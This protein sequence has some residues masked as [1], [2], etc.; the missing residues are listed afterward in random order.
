MPEC[1]KNIPG[2]IHVSISLTACEGN[3]IMQKQLIAGRRTGGLVLSAAALMLLAG[4]V[5]GPNY[6]EP[7]INSPESFTE[8]KAWSTAAGDIKQWWKNLNDPA[9]DSLVERAIKG[10]LDLREAEARVREARELRQ[11]ARSSELPTI[12]NSTGYKRQEDS[13]NTGSPNSNFP[14]PGNSYNAWNLG[15]DA[16]WELDFFGRVQRGVEAAEG[17]VQSAEFTAR[18][19]LVTLT[20]EVARNY[21]DLRTQQQRLT[22]TQSN[23]KTQEQTMS[24]AETRFKAGL[25]SE[26]DVAR[27][28]ANVETTRSQIPTIEAS[29]RRTMHRLAVLLGQNPGTLLDELMVAKAIPASPA[30]VPIGVPSELLRRRPDIRSVERQLAAQTAR[31]GVATGDLYPRITLGGS[32]GWNANRFATL[33]DA[34]SVAY[35]VGPALT[36]NIFDYGKI[37]ANIRANSARSE[38]LLA[39]YERTVITAFSDVE[40]ALSNF[41]REQTRQ[42]SLALAVVAGQRAVQLSTDLYQ[43]GLTD[44]N[45]VLD[46]QRQLLSLQDQQIQSQG[47]VVTNL[48]A[49]Y[50]SLGG[51]WDDSPDALS[52]FLPGKAV[53]TPAPTSETPAPAKQ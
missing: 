39:R 45:A 36:W 42:G 18:D 50:K 26:L 12:N 20:S 47:L 52:R 7:T 2:S 4:C 48:V 3:S 30:T 44:F 25:T 46:A 51:G 5:V 9:L 1:G 40:D 16:S 8:G 28:K 21:V 27:A 38:Q 15:F 19:V 10:N 43:Q 17:D 29:M 6:T 33:F 53:S 23:L 37:R 22:I 49:L 35:S 13:E 14:R 24:L 11:I 41:T 31:I 32:V 34:S